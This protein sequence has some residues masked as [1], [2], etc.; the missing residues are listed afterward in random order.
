MSKSEYD[1]TSDSHSERKETI[2]YLYI[3]MEL[4]QKNS[5]SKWLLQTKNRDQKDILRIFGQITKGVEFIHSKSLIHR[6]LKV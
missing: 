6:D 1:T 2:Q 5:L 4:C 3:Q